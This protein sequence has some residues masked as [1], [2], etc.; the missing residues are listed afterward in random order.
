MR[1]KRTFVRR[2]EHFFINT[3]FYKLNACKLTA[4][5]C[6][7]TVQIMNVEL[8]VG[9]KYACVDIFHHIAFFI[10]SNVQKFVNMVSQFD[11]VNCVH[12]SH[13]LKFNCSTNVETRKCTYGFSIK[14][15][16]AKQQT[17][18]GNIS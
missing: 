12:G 6:N 8:H 18:S 14:L 11:N 2:F 7:H 9:Y 5:S 17:I 15:T 16:F 13:M 10:A 1:Q 3:F 4:K